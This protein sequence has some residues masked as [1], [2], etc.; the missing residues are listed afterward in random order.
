MLGQFHE[1][2]I[3]ADKDSPDRQVVTDSS[4]DQAAISDDIDRIVGYLNNKR[5]GTN[6]RASELMQEITHRREELSKRSAKDSEE[7]IP[8]Q[9]NELARSVSNGTMSDLRANP[10]LAERYHT[11][12]RD[13]DE[14]L[15]SFRARVDEKKRLRH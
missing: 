10:I 15:D 13:L 3:M 2:E 12:C 6:E 5:S 7:D 8:K 11:F 4:R 9:L 14:L 1:V